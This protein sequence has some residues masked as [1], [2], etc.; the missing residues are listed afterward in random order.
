MLTGETGAGKSIL[1]DA[2]AAVLGSR[3]ES[4]QVR[5]GKDKA[6]VSA[7]F[8]TDEAPT[9]SRYLANNDLGGDDGECLLRRVIESSGR[10]R[11]Y[12]NGRAGHGATTQG[13]RR[14]PGGYPR[15]ACAPVAVARGAPSATCWTAMPAPP[16][17]RARL[18]QRFRAWQEIRLQ[19]LA[20]ETDAQA[21]E[22][23]REQLQWQVRELDALAFR[24]EE[25]EELQAEH[26]RLA[27]AASLIEAVQFSLDLL[28]EGEMST[29]AAVAS[30]SSRLDGMTDFDPQLKE[31]VAVLEPAQIQLQEA[32]YSLRHYQGRLDLDPQR[33]RETEDRLDAVHTASRKFRLNPPR[34]RNVWRK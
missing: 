3:A 23:E 8:S 24:A 15:P 28:S 22:A 26:K 30:V 2:L 19:R 13:R 1:I 4:G 14:T 20:L 12:V 17:W 32:V 33:L 10:S 21:L 9:V 6:E 16:I 29:L 18:R 7:E 34:C 31:I 27:H 5:E 11:A 25:W